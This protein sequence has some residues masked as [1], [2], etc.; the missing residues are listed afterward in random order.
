MRI[1]DSFTL[2]SRSIARSKLRSLGLLVGIVLPVALISG[3]STSVDNTE[4]RRLADELDTNAPD[5]VLTPRHIGDDP[6][7]LLPGL[8]RYALQLGNSSPVG[9]AIPVV[10]VPLYGLLSRDERDTAGGEEAE[11]G[12]KTT[13]RLLGLPS[14]LAPSD[15]WLIGIDNFTTLGQDG[16]L[17]DRDT[18]TKW[19]LRAD[20]RITLTRR[21]AG[22]GEMSESLELYVQGIVDLD[23]Q[24]RQA[25]AR[26]RASF[27][28]GSY[29]YPAVI[30]S[31]DLL[32]RAMET[33]EAQ[34]QAEDAGHTPIGQESSPGARILIFLD[35]Q[36]LF[37]SLSPQSV[38]EQ[39]AQLEDLILSQTQVDLS[40]DNNAMGIVRQVEEGSQDMR[41][42][43][44]ALS[45]PLL[46][47]SLYIGLVLGE[48]IL[49]ARKREIGLL[50]IR[51]LRPG[52]LLRLLLLEAL[53]IGVA[54]SLLG[55][56]V[57]W[58]TARLFLPASS[59]TK[60]IV[61]EAA[62][63]DG[64]WLSPPSIQTIMIAF[65]AGIVMA[66]APTLGWA[67]K[68][69]R[70]EPQWMRQDPGTGEHGQGQ[71]D[72]EG[73][74]RHPGAKADIA[75]V[76]LALGSVAAGILTRSG[77]SLIHLTGIWSMIIQTVLPALYSLQPLVP[78]FLIIG[79]TR[80]VVRRSL[81]IRTVTRS[82]SPLS[83]QLSHLVQKAQG[84]VRTQNW[85]TCLVVGLCL[86]FG[87]LVTVSMSSI[88]GYREAV[89]PLIT[90]G[91][92]CVIGLYGEEANLTSAYLLGKGANV[93][94]SMEIVSFFPEG[95]F[96]VIDPDTYPI[97]KRID[98]K[99]RE[100]IS[101]SLLRLKET[102]MGALIQGT[103]P[104]QPIEKKYYSGDL[105]K[106]TTLTSAGSYRVMPGLGPTD[107]LGTKLTSTIVSQETYQGLKDRI[108]ELRSHPHIR[109]LVV[110]NLPA[111]RDLAE[112]RNA[113]IGSLPDHLWGESDIQIITEAS[114]IPV[115]TGLSLFVR[116]ELCYLVLA[117][118]LGV[119]T[120]IVS[121][122]NHARPMIWSLGARGLRNWRIFLLVS[123]MGL[124]PVILGLATGTLTG[125]L[126]G[127]LWSVQSA[128]PLVP[129]RPIPVLG[130]DFALVVLLST[131]VFTT[132]VLITSYWFT[133]R[134]QRTLPV[135]DHWPRSG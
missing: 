48:N 112:T 60:S 53:V 39:I 17:V 19:R 107:W 6:A 94:I 1:L 96:Y 73:R 134:A 85:R 41:E 51:G 61:T 70:I 127:Y 93:A 133:A 69:V 74:G 27:P 77:D 33:L 45:L 9:S 12:K 13:I 106:Y 18:A 103:T 64:K 47:L 122:L 49:S 75:L 135:I 58:A 99:L 84:S 115:R 105:S 79:T 56:T 100:E 117:G 59:A 43:F 92:M 131:G 86:G 78:F 55:V 89:A 82:L 8:V 40:V 3:V 23:D 130:A 132:A 118:L 71:E 126:T 66:L 98:P 124:S 29:D 104:G 54:A 108:P 14:S 44:V 5:L 30:I 65:S 37:R 113:L 36:E 50:R 97:D 76:G 80:L 15:A 38:E 125:I 88:A 46:G 34:I 129:V 114:T 11:D 111:G 121:L 57:G 110:A 2:A 87:G 24:V 123:T 22:T 20:D 68:A 91:D 16:C 116:S 4:L 42:Q 109:Y 7:A 35:R 28:G 119:A 32:P 83:G 10:E 72:A 128:D 120:I 67:R 102:D 81:A 90:G 52:S 101:Q 21:H 31:L 25:G 63:P 62:V 26:F 95:S